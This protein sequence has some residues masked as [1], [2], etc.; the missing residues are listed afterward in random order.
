MIVVSGANAGKY[1]YLK[2]TLGRVTISNHIDKRHIE[3]QRSQ[4]VR[5]SI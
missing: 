3:G 1:G 5:I 2:E 4:D